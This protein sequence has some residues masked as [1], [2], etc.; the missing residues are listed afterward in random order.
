MLCVFK[1]PFSL[2]SHQ[3]PLTTHAPMRIDDG[4]IIYYNTKLIS[5]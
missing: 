4:I 5:F 2:P 1:L 3:T